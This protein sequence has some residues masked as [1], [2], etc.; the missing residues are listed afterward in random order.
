MEEG[1]VLAAEKR[2]KSKLMDPRSVEKILEVR[3]FFSCSQSKK[4]EQIH[5]HIGTAISGLAGDAKTLVDFARVEAQN[6]R[7]TYNEEITLQAL[8]QAVADT[9]LNFGEG[10]MNSKQKPIVLFSSFI[11]LTPTLGLLLLFIYF[12]NYF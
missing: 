6:H 3:S 5:S 4:K 9:A 11:Y 8:T 10:D 12:I 7:F 1:V 2:I